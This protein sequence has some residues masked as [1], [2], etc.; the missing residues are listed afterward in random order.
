MIGAV[1]V[2]VGLGLFFVF[3]SYLTRRCPQCGSPFG[4]RKTGRKVRG[5]TLDQEQWKCR[6]C[7]HATLRVESRDGS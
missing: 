5:F 1:L 6:R 7:G 3:A 2:L 4:L